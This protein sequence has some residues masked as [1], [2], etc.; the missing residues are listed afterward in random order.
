MNMNKKIAWIGALVFCA[1]LFAE[2]ALAI[3]P[4]GYPYGY[5]GGAYPINPS[6]GGRY[7]PYSQP[8]RVGGFFGQSS[9][10]LIGLRPGYATGPFMNSWTRYAVANSNYP[11]VG[12]FFG[13]NPYGYNNYGLRPGTFTYGYG[14]YGSGYGNINYISHGIL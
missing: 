5:A 4:A 2:A 11:R 6:I 14:G 3:V 12:G 7:Y 10:F 8:A 13:Y 1:L 9:T